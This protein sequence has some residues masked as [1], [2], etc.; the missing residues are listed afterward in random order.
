MIGKTSTRVAVT[1]VKR[2][3]ELMAA[4][5]LLHS[6][7]GSAALEAVW[8]EIEPDDRFDR[9]VAAHYLADAQSDPREELRW[10]ELALAAATDAAPEEFSDVIPG[11]TLASFLPSLHLNLAADYERLGDLPRARAH[12]AAAMQ[13]ASALP[14]TELGELTRQAIDRITRRLVSMLVR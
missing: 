4:I 10:D 6:G 8:A 13:A 3:A 7:A 5:E 12:A 2:T 9:C 11:V 14:A 1:A